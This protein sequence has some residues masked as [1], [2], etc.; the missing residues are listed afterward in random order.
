MP[1]SIPIGIE[2]FCWPH[3]FGYAG[4]DHLLKRTGIKKDGNHG[5]ETV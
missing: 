1:G 4:T 5:W 2:L 3:Y